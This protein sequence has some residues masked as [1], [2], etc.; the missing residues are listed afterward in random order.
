VQF[1][2][3]LD[4]IP[5]TIERSSII[6]NMIAE[7]AKVWLLD[8]TDRCDRC[9]AQAYVKVIGNS[10]EL[11]FCSHHYNKIMDNAEGYKK[12]MNFM[13]EVIDERKKL[14]E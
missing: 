9:A 8:A 11:L 7:D 1:F 6:M 5:Q 10:G 12:M 3:V 2:T 4:F 14:E 13:I